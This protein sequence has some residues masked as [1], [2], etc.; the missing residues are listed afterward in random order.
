MSPED[1]VV[2][3]AAAIFFAIALCIALGAI[4]EFVHAVAA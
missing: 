2:Y 3:S 1:A 4:A